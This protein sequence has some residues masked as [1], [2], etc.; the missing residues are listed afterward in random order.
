MASSLTDLLK[1]GMKHFSGV[2]EVVIANIDAVR[3]FSQITKTSFG[4]RGKVFVS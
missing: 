4:P 3:S 2:S 1:E